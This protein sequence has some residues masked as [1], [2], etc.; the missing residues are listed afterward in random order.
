MT[1]PVDN[2]QDQP[3]DPAAYRHQLQL[4]K[5]AHCARPV[6]HRGVHQFIS[7]LTL[8]S[9]G[10]R[11]AMVVYLAGQA[12]GLDSTEVQIKTETEPA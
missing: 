1:G 2:N 9:V 8:H 10:T 12:G 4:L 6:L 7:G 3:L 11:P 5:S